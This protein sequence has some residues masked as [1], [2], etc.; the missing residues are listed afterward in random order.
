MA[1]EPLFL[2]QYMPRPEKIKEKG[3]HASATFNC[4]F[5]KFP[6]YHIEESSFSMDL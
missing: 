3:S 6:L 4:L 2:L 5:I 1:Y